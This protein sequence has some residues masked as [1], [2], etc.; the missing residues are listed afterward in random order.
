MPKKFIKR[1]MPDP[2]KIREQKIM[3]VFGSSLHKPNLWYL[4][5]RSVASA[6]A[7]GLFFAWIPFP[8]QM[9]LAAAGAIIFNANLPISVGLVWITNPFTIPP[10]FAFAYWVGTVVLNTP[11]HDFHFEASLEWFTNS[12][13]TIGAPLITGS[14]ICAIVSSLMG[15]I[16]IQLLWRRGIMKRIQQR[17]NA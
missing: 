15:Y 2:G 8:F 7:V 4:N 1:F 17:K 14:L 5:R 12:M 9:L 6:F 11:E 10:F 3:R 13:G 16:G